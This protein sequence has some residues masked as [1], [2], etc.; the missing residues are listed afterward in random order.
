MKRALLLLLGVLLIPAIP[1][2]ALAVLDLLPAIFSGDFP[3]ISREPLAVLLGY[4]AWTVVF[5]AIPP[6]ARVYVLG[7][8]LTHAAWGLMTF[9]RVRRLRVRDDGGSVEITSPGF[10]TTLAPYFVP[11]YLLV[12]LLA[13]LVAGLFADMGP[14]SSCWLF[15]VGLAYGFHVTYTVKSLA[16][17][18]PDIRVYGRVLS[19]VAIIVINLLILG[20]GLVAVTPAGLPAYHRRLAVRTLRSY[21]TAAGAV[22]RGGE[23][24]AAALRHR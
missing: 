5:A 14:Y 24:I 13:R 10:F 3:W 22:A 21:E 15:L 8:E 20:Y 16:G 19:C 23:A 6:A 11:F 2:V 18:Q 9:S 4:A 12:V 7:H 1:G 17:R